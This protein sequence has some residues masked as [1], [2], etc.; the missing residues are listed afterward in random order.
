MSISKV[1][2]SSLRK[3][4]QVDLM[5]ILFIQDIKATYDPSTSISM[6]ASQYLNSNLTICYR[7]MPYTH[8]DGRLRPDLRLGE[9][10]PSVRKVAAV[11]LWFQHMAGLP[12]VL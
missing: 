12:S 9:S 5:L 2:E 7:T 1:G 8:E 6:T 10:D 4:F 3:S 11:V